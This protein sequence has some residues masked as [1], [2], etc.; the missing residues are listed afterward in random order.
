MG[1]VKDRLTNS[2]LKK[3]RSWR[4]F[5]E[6]DLSIG[7]TVEGL[8]RQA[9]AQQKRVDGIGTVWEELVPPHVRKACTV[10][11]L[12]AGVLTVK[13]GGASGRFQVDRWLRSGGAALLNRKGG[14]KRVKIV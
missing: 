6:K 3:L 13:A 10:E 5:R 2:D 9:A 4:T 11:G 12:A 14:V 8:A 7:A 1:P